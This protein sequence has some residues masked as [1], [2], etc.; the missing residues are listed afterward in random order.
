MCSSIG[1][2]QL[3][4][5]SSKIDSVAVNSLKVIE[6]SKTTKK[7]NM[8]VSKT[9]NALYSKINE[10]SSA[11]RHVSENISILSNKSES[12]GNIVLAIESIAE[13]T[14]LLALNAAR[15]AA[16][17]GESGKGFAVVAD[18]VRKLAEQ[19]SISTKEISDTIKEI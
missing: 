6:Y 15:E 4:K 10:A 1:L 13:Q 11:T 3:N 9:T 19:T 5:L 8:D 18:E 7:V 16:R 2:E 12:I 17:A 14:N